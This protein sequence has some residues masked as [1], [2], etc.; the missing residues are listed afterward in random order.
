MVS[1]MLLWIPIV[2]SAVIVFVV[3]SIIHMVLT[4]HRSDFQKLVEED[5]VMAALRSFNI[6][7]GDYIMPH[8][9]SMQAMK[10]PAFVERMKTGPVAWMTFMPAG[11]T[12]IGSSLILWFL[13]SI[14]VSIIAAYVGAHALPRGASYLAV[15]RI[16][17]C[18]AFTGYAIALI[19]NSIWAKRKWSTT[20]KQLFDGLVYG[21]LTAGVFG[22][23]WPR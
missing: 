14:L 15:F 19:Q 1:V 18:V 7:P 9:G 17:G 5:E 20:L 2:L 21:L 11:Q 22:W 8:A 10:E 4:Y 12:S 6:P 3:S 23:L 13:Y 16:V